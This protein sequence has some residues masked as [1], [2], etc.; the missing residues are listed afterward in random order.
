LKA[1]P[2]V[3]NFSRRL[4]R[5]YDEIQWYIFPVTYAHLKRAMDVI[6]ASLALLIVSPFLLL[7]A[8]A[9]RLRLGSPIIFR[10][11]RPGLDGR[12]FTLHKFRTMRTATGR[13]GKPL[14]DAARLAPLG[15]FLRAGSLDEL[16]ELVNVVRGDM[17]LVGPRPL[18]LEYLPLYS[19]E[20]QRRHAV[21]PGLTG[22]AQVNGR[23][24]L[25]WPE[26]FA[27][28]I[29]YVDHLSLALDCRILLRTVVHVWRR[30]GIS[31][32]GHV[33]MEA[34]RGNSH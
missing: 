28:D 4:V 11:T 10:Q 26:K 6:L 14:P 19:A 23:N 7:I 32:D 27:L 33:T 1:S 3:E 21:R 2:Q 30:D 31:Q 20:Q 13:D 16:P 18:L 22:W 24:A 25:T 15:R 34:F 8:A 17:S 29:Y 9:V 12:P 5:N